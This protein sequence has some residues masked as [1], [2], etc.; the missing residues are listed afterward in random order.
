MRTGIT[1][2]ALCIM[3][4]SH[5]ALIDRGN[6]MIYDDVLNITWLQNANLAGNM[7][8][9]DSLDWAGDL[10]YG[11]FSDWRLPSIDVNN[12]GVV[13]YCSIS[14]EAECR[15]TEFGYMYFQNMMGVGGDDLT[16]DQLLFTNIQGQHWFS[17]E[18]ALATTTAWVFLFSDSLQASTDKSGLYGAWAVRDGDVVV[19]LPAGIWLLGSG[20]IGLGA[21]RRAKQRS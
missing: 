15:D 5:A 12:D 2:L 1:I 10:V 14:S 16:G 4:T 19:P 7:S 21:V 3:S 6:G 11:G 20:L 8:W 18:N 17:E 13:V 9:Q